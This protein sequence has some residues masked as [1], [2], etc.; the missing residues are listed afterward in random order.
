MRACG[1]SY[2][3]LEK[4]KAL[5][6]LPKPMTANNYKI[7]NPLNIIVEEVANETIRDASEDLFSKSED[8]ND[9]TIIDTAVV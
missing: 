6:N 3:S 4:L 7:V 1:Q 8:P 9:D 5:T 2:A